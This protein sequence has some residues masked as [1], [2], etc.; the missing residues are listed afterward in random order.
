MP[1]DS[2]S[3]L[4]CSTTTFAN[5][6]LLRSR[7]ILKRLPK[8]VKTRPESPNSCGNPRGKPSP[9][10]PRSV[11]LY[12]VVVVAAPRARDRERHHA[13]E[14]GNEKEFHRFPL[15]LT[16][17]TLAPAFLEEKAVGKMPFRPTV[18]LGSE[19]FPLNWC[20][21]RTSSSSVFVA[22]STRCW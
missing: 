22:R 16:S 11:M 5:V 17:G 15:P 10:E 7:S 19:L 14:Q 1:A 2:R 12:V 3:L 21:N 13:G 4:D 6:G 8:S 9:S 20:L 18:A